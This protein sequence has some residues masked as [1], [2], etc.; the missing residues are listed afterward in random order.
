MQRIV[1]SPRNNWQSSVEKIGFGFHT[2][3]IPYWDESVYYSFSMPEVLQLEQATEELWEMCLK[4]V[5][6]TID[7]QLFDL[8]LIPKTFISYLVSSWNNDLPTVLGRFDFCYR[9]NQIKLLEFNA[10]TPTS[11]F[12]AAIVQWFWLQ[13]FDPSKDQFNS[14]HEKLIRTWQD[15]RPKFGGQGLYFSCMKDSLEDFTNTEYLRD[16][17]MQAGINT[18]FIFI[19]DIGWDESSK[20]FADLDCKPLRNFFK[21]YPWEFMVKEPFASRFL[22]DRIQPLVFEPVWKMILS[23]KAILALLWQLYPGHP[24][25]LPADR[26]AGSLL[27]F[28]K[29]P[30]LSR[31]GANI[32]LFKEGR[33]IYKT[34]GSYGGEGYVY[35]ELCE[36]P[37]FDNNYPVIGSWLIGG[38]S[39]GIGVRESKSL[40]TDNGSRFVPHLIS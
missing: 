4:A 3:N 8:F 7:N 5:Q 11:L 39:A 10:D 33:S 29:K 28:V 24:Y 21:L 14:L 2:G 32:E 35:Q 37:C 12:E 15:I 18:H 27:N 1:T 34:E 31:E 36:L 22:E 20:Q 23:N 13:D 6:Y 17:A 16:C 26:K 30:L 25:L 40:V 38:E 19:D 9:G